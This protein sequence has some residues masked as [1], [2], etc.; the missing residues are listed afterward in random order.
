LMKAPL[1]FAL[2]S[3]PP[4]GMSRSAIEAIAMLDDVSGELTTELM[5]RDRDTALK[6]GRPLHPRDAYA[7]LDSVRDTRKNRI[8][9]LRPAPK[10]AKTPPAQR[11][12]SR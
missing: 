5:V 7:A 1:R 6:T 12:A 8:S 11:S 10:T 4:R 2:P 3:L 9:Y